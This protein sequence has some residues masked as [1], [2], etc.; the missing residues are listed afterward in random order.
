M[1]KGRFISSNKY[2][3]E[4]AD[5]I[6]KI[7]Y[8]HGT[9]TVFNDFIL[10]S[11]YAISNAVDKLH[12]K[13]REQSYSDVVKKYNK[14]ELEGF[15]QLNAKLI[16]GLEECMYTVDIL[17]ELFASLGQWNGNNGQFF[18]P[19]SVS[20]AMAKMLIN[21]SDE[22]I[23]KKGYITVMEPTCG[24][25]GLVLA[26]ANTLSEMKLNPTKVMCICAVDNDIRCAM[27]TYIQ[28]SYLGLPAVVIH[29]DSL[30]AKEYSRFYTPIYILDGWLRKEK[31]SITDAISIDDEKMKSMM[32]PVYPVIK[33]GIKKDENKNESA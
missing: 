10:M 3:K 27:M 5:I 33:Y 7:A 29:G 23:E 19:M 24:S 31:M 26:A 18:T 32:A 9:A 30:C 16:C 4:M 28:L 1:A 17:G 13:E 21:S 8:R 12:F 20:Q 25:G 11:A 2:V 15:V 22:I 6:L 14:D